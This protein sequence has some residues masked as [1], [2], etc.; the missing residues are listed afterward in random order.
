MGNLQDSKLEQLARHGNGHYAYVDNLAEDFKTSP[1]AYED[2]FRILN[3]GDPRLVDRALLVGEL[4]LARWLLH[5]VR[6]SLPDV[7]ADAESMLADLDEATRE[8][9]PA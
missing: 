4:A 9:A 6:R 2:L 8:D 3:G 7:V 5:G 1:A